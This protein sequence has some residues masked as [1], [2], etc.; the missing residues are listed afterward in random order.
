MNLSAVKWIA[1]R[2]IAGNGALEKSSASK[3]L[4][5]PCVGYA[6]AVMVARGVVGTLP[7]RG[8]KECATPP[9]AHSSSSTVSVGNGQRG[10]AHRPES[11]N[12]LQAA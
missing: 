10:T 4:A 6:V 8:T 1:M 7:V 11:G 5:I 3:C 2:T 9:A 12:P